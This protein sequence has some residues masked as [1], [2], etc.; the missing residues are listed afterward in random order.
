MLPKL[1]IVIAPSTTQA[2]AEKI[3]AP[4]PVVKLDTVYAGPS[5]DAPVYPDVVTLP[6]P[7]C[8]YTKLEPFVLTP[9]SI[10]V[11]RFTQDGMPVKSMDVPLVDACA[12]DTVSFCVAA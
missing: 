5:E 6:A 1:V 4:K 3:R 8:N 2:A 7:I 12:V 10:T 11:M 9:A